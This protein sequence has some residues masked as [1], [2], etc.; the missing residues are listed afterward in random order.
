M[1]E[2]PGAL[3]ADLELGFQATSFQDWPPHLAGVLFFP[4]CNLRC[5]W[6]H[7][8]GL[9]DARLAHGLQPWSAIRASLA[10]RVKVLSGVVAS[11]GEALLHPALMSVLGEVKALGYRVRLDTNGTLPERLALVPQGLIDE[12]A[13]DL[14]LDP[15]G[16]SLDGQAATIGLL[17]NQGLAH[18]FRLVW[19]PGWHNESMVPAIAQLIGR[20]SRLIL[21]PFKP[22]VCLDPTWAIR[23]PCSQETLGRVATLL[24]TEDIV[25]ILD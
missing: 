22:G 12:V 1:S 18:E 11:G 16:R 8:P 4:G 13:M 15:N 24:R 6:C 17:R 19:V 23:P 7:N 20:G 2:N 9:V 5:P 3:L 14:K 21:R 10:R 25:L